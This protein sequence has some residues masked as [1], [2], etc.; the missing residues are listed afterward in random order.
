MCDDDAKYGH[1]PKEPTRSEIMELAYKL[2]PECWISY[3]GKPKQFKQ[4]IEI[5]RTAAIAE[6][7]KQ[8]NAN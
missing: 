2:D 7:R 5:R 3:S 4:Y 6:A 1:L 8:L